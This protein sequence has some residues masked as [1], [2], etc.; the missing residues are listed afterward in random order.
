MLQSLQLSENEVDMIEHSVKE[1]E[2]E[3]DTDREALWQICD[4]PISK[5]YAAIPL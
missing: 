5:S 3:L 2:M 4:I 1:M